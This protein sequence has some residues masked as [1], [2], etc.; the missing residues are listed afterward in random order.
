MIPDVLTVTQTVQLRAEHRYCENHMLSQLIVV[1]VN[2][3]VTHIPD[4]MLMMLMSTA[5]DSCL[6]CSVPTDQITFIQDV[7]QMSLRRFSS[8]YHTLFTVK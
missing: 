4:M 5:V 6:C 3:G 2:L 1:A 8:R 7:G